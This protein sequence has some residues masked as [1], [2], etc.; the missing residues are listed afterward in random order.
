MPAPSLGPPPE[1]RVVVHSRPGCHLCTDA[2]AVVERVCRARGEAFAVRSILEDP[3]AHAAYA[4]LIPVVVV[5]GTVVAQ[6]R[7]T[8]EALE[9]AL[10]AP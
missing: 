7:V 6:W 3:A 10:G 2:I 5:D 9:A 1:P 4:E 8:E